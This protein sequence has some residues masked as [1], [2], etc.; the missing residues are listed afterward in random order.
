MIQ[1]MTGYGRDQ[2]SIDGINITIELKSVNSRYFEFNCRLP[3]GYLFLENKLKDFTQSKISRGKVEMYVSIESEGQNDIEI[4]VNEAYAQSY[5]SALKTLSKK[6]KIKNDVS[7]S[8]FVNNSDIFKISRK[9]IDEDGVTASALLVA[10]TAIQKFISM[11]EVEGEKLRD[12]VVSR[13]NEILNMVEFVET[14]SPKT[15]EAY[16]QKLENKIKDLLDNSQFDES[17]IITET[18]IYADKVAV[19]EETVRLRSHIAQF[20]KLV[21]EGG[22]IGRKLDFIVQEMNRETNTI[23]SKAQDIEIA[24]VVV[25]IK[26]E[27]EKIREQIQNIE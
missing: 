26:S 17:R 6:L 18:A 20:V 24:Q 14:Q 19:S 7:T 21:N 16:R 25:N 8:N 22:A 27:I 3:K 13:T 4:S 12:D 1:S 11:R 9:E 5:I 23:G 15:V 10:D 2:K